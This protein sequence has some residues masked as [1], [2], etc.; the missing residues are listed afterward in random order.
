[1]RSASWI[2]AAAYVAVWIWSAA[3]LPDRVPVHFGLTGEAD[4][5]SSKPA[6]LVLFAVLGAVVFGLMAWSLRLV[7]RSDLT[8]P[9][10]NVPHRDWWTATPERLERVRRMLRRDL[11]ALTVGMA[12]LFLALQVG[13]VVAAR[14]G[15]GMGPLALT[16]VLGLVGAMLLYGIWAA[17]RRYRP[18]E[19][20]A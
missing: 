3:V 17:V 9:W 5:W 4:R 14:N 2:L 19:G 11:E 16:V 7:D 18:D 10:V 8:G 15:G 1:M 6:A 20:V 13:T 12:V